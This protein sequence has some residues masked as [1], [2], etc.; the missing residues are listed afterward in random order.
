MPRDIVIEWMQKPQRSL[1]TSK[2]ESGDGI[3]RE[4]KYMRNFLHCLE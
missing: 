4:K 3:S 1:R 2:E